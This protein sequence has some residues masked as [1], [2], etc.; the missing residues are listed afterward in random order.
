[1]AVSDI[2]PPGAARDHLDFIGLAK[3]HEASHFY[4]TQRVAKNGRV[5]DIWITLSILAD[6]Q[7]NAM[8]VATTERELTDRR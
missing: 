6:S 2:L 8:A 5:I 7:G 4:E 1:M 3:R